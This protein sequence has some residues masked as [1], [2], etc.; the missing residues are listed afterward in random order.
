MNRIAMLVALACVAPVSTVD[1]LAELNAANRAA[2]RFVQIEVLAKSGPIIVQSGDELILIHKG[3][4]DEKT[5]IPKVY[6][7]RKAIAH[8]SLGLWVLLAPG[9]RDLDDMRREHLTTI[10]ERI[11]KAKLY[12]EKLELAPEVRDRQLRILNESD[13]FIGATLEAGKV[14]RE[15][16]L[17]FIAKVKP[18]TMVNAKEAGVAQL[19]S[20]HAQ[21]SEWRKS[22]SPEEWKSLRIVIIG[23][24]MPRVQN[25]ATQYF[26]RLLG[27]KGE[28]RRIIY[29]E[30]LWDEPKA[31]NLLATH[32]I[33]EGVARAF[34]GNDDR[35]NMDL[36]ADVATEYIK[37]MK[38]EE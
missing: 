2:Y 30:S 19:D 13:A 28:C 1:P 27:E 6:H 24:Q 16:L 36:L 7:D 5:V 25:L 4:R 26:A 33:D 38:F 21:V 11:G 14:S 3:K 34:F 12:F 20:M 8:V 23:A 29:A 37:R 10:R 35:M 17:A 22:L 31:L 18:D 9:D 32:Q 15:K